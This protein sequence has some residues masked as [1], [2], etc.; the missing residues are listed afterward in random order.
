M[1]YTLSFLEK[2]L[3]LTATPHT[4][5]TEREF[6]LA[7][8][9]MLDPKTNGGFP[10]DVQP[11]VIVQVMK[12]APRPWLL[13]ESESEAL[14]CGMNPYN[15]AEGS[16]HLA[17]RGFSVHSTIHVLRHYIA[18]FPNT[19][20]HAFTVR[21]SLKVIT[22]RLGFVFGAREGQLAIWWRNLP[23]DQTASGGN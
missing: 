18:Q 9:L 16:L 5:W 3:P 11:E 1:P 20:I 14:V 6:M 17:S 15:G 13:V 23:M 21:P 8:D 10:S 12:A 19:R 4:E 7:A 22:R 2:S